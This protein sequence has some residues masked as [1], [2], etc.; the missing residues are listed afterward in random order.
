MINKKTFESTF[1]VPLVVNGFKRK[2]SSWYRQAEGVLQVVNLQRS[3]Y[4]AQ[5]YVN[6]CCVPVGMEVDGMP[7]PKVHNCPIQIRL[8][9]AFPDRKGEIENVFDLET[10]SLNAAEPKEQLARFAQELIFP[11]LANA[12]DVPSLRH[13]IEHGRFEGGSANI[14]ARRQ[15]GVPVSCPLLTWL[16]I[17]EPRSLRTR[18]GT[19]RYA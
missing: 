2:A 10:T 15:L 9:E 8:T 7:M 5:Y 6:L 17:V 4:G 11:F 13:A 1:G 16:R 19:I 18:R 12:K 14:A 3:A